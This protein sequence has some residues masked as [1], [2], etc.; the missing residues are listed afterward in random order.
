MLRRKSAGPRA[1]RITRDRWVTWPASASC[2][3]RPLAAGRR[4]PGQR[5]PGPRTGKLR[6]SLAGHLAAFGMAFRVAVG[7]G[8]RVLRLAE[9]GEHDRAGDGEGEAN[10][11][12]RG[13]P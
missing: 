12:H 5:F 10:R 8:L 3:R 13:E 7:A 9:A 6:Q 1:T 11:G 2:P 4:A